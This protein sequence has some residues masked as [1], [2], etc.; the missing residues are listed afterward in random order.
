[1]AGKVVGGEKEEVIGNR[2]V[3]LGFSVRS[4]E[5]NNI[6]VFSCFFFSFFLSGLLGLVRKR[7]VISSLYCVCF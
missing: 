2:K 4:F 3:E 5:R 6:K 1:V 7:C